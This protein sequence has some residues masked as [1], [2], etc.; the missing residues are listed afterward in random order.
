MSLFGI[1][2]GDKSSTSSS[3]TTTNVA[4]NYQATG[5]AGSVVLGAGASGT[6][7][8]STADPTVLH[9]ALAANE[10]VSGE[11]LGATLAATQDAIRNNSTVAALAIQG[12]DQ[13]QAQSI[14]Y[15][16]SATSNFTAALDNANNSGA[17]LAAA[18]VSDN[19]QL[20]NTALGGAPGSFQPGTV[21]PAQQSLS[22]GGVM[23]S[24]ISFF[25]LLAALAS[26]AAIAYYTI[27][28]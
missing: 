6:V 26:L 20:V 7:Q 14:G 19:A 17:Q 5:A 22:G 12:A 8:I 15:L 27:E 21:Q 2:S 11:A 3:T 23:S 1:F 4:K 24:G 18:V 13:S 28:L 10:A 25:T 9:D 16:T